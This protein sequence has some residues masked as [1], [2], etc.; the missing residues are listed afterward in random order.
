MHIMLTLIDREKISRGLAD[1]LLFAEIAVRIS[2]DRSVV[3]RDVACHVGRSGYRAVVTRWVRCSPGHRCRTEVAGQ[4]LPGDRSHRR[5]QRRR[6]PFE[7]HC[8]RATTTPAGLPRRGAGRQRRRRHHP[9]VAGTR[10]QECAGPQEGIAASG[11]AAGEVEVTIDGVAQDL[12][13]RSSGPFGFGAQRRLGIRPETE[14]R[15]H[16]A[17]AL[18]V[19]PRAVQK[20]QRSA[21]T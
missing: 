20:P 9:A 13:L 18:A 3:S 4:V 7:H 19:V 12:L 10:R 6:R 8:T 11:I 15:R 16:L 21:S 17:M 1:D 2:R 5:D 14:V